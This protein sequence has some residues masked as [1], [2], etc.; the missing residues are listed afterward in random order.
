MPEPKLS[1]AATAKVI[2]FI[3]PCLQFLLESLVIYL[4]PAPGTETETPNASSA[5]LPYHPAYHSNCNDYQFNKL[6]YAL[7]VASHFAT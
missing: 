7:G 6:L 3:I 5:C 1:F 2:P 4:L